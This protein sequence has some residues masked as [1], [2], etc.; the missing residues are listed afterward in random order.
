MTWRCCRREPPG[1]QF[2]WYSTENS[3]SRAIAWLRISGLRQHGS[4]RRMYGVGMVYCMYMEEGVELMR[5]PKEY[6][7]EPNSVCDRANELFRVSFEYKRR[8]SHENVLHWM[9]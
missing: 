2:G 6:S 8:Y 4:G 5:N 3:W 9:R 1:L 7:T